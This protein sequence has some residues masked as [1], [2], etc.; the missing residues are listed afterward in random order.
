MAVAE[1]SGLN[2]HGRGSAVRDADS[3]LMFGGNRSRR[4][5]I[6]VRDGSAKTV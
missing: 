6:T 5:S 2:E 3:G 4:C 1:D